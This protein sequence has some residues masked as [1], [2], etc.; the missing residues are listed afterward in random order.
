M[1]KSKPIQNILKCSFKILLIVLVPVVVGWL[2]Y[3][4]FLTI[5]FN[6]NPFATNRAEEVAKPIEKSLIEAGAVKV[7]DHGAT[8]REPSNNESWYSSRFQLNVGK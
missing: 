4:G 5:A 8:G 1:I 2:V 6:G 3:W 7:C